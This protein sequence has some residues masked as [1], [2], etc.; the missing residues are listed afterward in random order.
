MIQGVQDSSVCFQPFYQCLKHPFPLTLIPCH[1]DLVLRIFELS[2]K[3][4][5]RVRITFARRSNLSDYAY[6]LRRDKRDSLAFLS[7]GSLADHSNP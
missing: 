3:C 4:L 7:A 1:I 6:Q 5:I 2:C